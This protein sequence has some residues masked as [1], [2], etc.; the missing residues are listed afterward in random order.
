MLVRTLVGIGIPSAR[1][2]SILA[3]SVLLW[4]SPIGVSGASTT[5][6]DRSSTC[7]VSIHHLWEI[8]DIWQDD[9][10]IQAA[11]PSVGASARGWRCVWLVSSVLPDIAGE[12]RTVSMPGKVSSPRLQ[13]AFSAVQCQPI[14]LELIWAPSGMTRQQWHR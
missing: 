12:Q 10:D 2:L 5:S 9:G 4:S 11:L 6:D 13:A 3:A 14:A 7:H 1:A 8:W